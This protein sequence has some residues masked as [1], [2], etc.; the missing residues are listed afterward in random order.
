MIALFDGA[1][2]PEF[3]AATRATV[4]TDTLVAVNKADL[5]DQAREKELDVQDQWRATHFLSVKTG[6]GLEL[7]LAELTARVAALCETGQDAPLTRTRHRHALEECVAA[8][9]RAREAD[10]PELAAEDLRLAARALGRITGT[11]DVEDLLDVVFAE[12][13]IGK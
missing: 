6:F 13:C 9:R 7:F 4:T 3:D 1:V 5:L 11:V 12:F 10:L 2:H 8:L